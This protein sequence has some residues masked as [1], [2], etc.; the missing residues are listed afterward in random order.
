VFY[1][2]ANNLA[3]DFVNTLAADANGDVELLN[4]FRDLIDWAGQVKVLSSEQGAAL[5]RNLENSPAKAAKVL[6]SA[7]EFR[8]RL[9]GMAFALSHGRHVDKKVLDTINAKLRER[10][11][12]TEVREAEEG[13]EKVFLAEFHDLSQVLVPIAESAADLLCYGDPANVRKC[14]NEKCV[15]YFY[16][17]SKN[18]R[19]RWCSMAACGNR[20]KASAFYSRKKKGP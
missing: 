20:A 7:R 17:T 6:E 11:G 12:T 10:L 8:S 18:H 4:D 13:Y 1:L 5:A 16:D 2:I 9:K 3:L 15:L 19:R 14:E